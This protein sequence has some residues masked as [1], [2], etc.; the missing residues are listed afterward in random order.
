MS[1]KSQQG[2]TQDSS[3]ESSLLRHID[4]LVSIVDKNYQ[5]RAISH[6][7]EL[8]FGCTQEEIIGK[9]VHEVHGEDVFQNSLKPQLDKTLAGEEMR[10]Q[11]SRPNHLGKT[12][13]LDVRH[14]VYSGPLTEGNGVAIVVRDI[15]D[16]I[17]ANNALKEERKLL[18][19]V[20]D[21]IPDF[22]FTKNP[23]GTYQ[24]CNKSFTEFLG[25]KRNE[26]IGKTDFEL[27]SHAS[28]EYISN[29]DSEVR[30]SQQS[31]RHDEWVTYKDG[32][33][34]LLDMHKLPLFDGDKTNPGI[35]GIGRNVTY[36][37]EAEQK[38]LMAALVFDATP[39]P[40]IIL[41]EKGVVISSNEAA[42]EQFPSLQN[43]ANKLH[44][45]DIFYCPATKAINLE[46]LADQN[47][48]WC[49]E[50]YSHDSM[51]HLATINV[52]HGQARQADKYVLIIRDENTHKS[53]TDN[54]KDKAYQDALTGLPNRRLF[55][56]RLESA[57]LRAERQF[58]QLAVLYIDLN[59]FKP[60]NDQHGHSAGDKA[61]VQIAQR[62]K[63]NFRTTDTLARL[64]G[65]EFVALV[66][67]DDKHQA[68]AIAR[69]VLNNLTAPLDLGVN[70]T[71]T[72]SAS[73]GI[74]LFPSS[75]GNAEELIQKAD[76]AMY[77]AK[78]DS[79]LYYWIYEAEASE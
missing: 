17:E 32:R 5:Y 27:M 55:Y 24:A 2:P 79:N 72:I 44:I 43:K 77:K 45:S 47:G 33:K 10:F 11:F 9:Y 46:T 68:E 34:R 3:T 23:N 60:I 40:C 58:N 7:Y 56:S 69:K 36:E 76:E 18:N 4:D 38:L 67:I 73:I 78:R 20:I 31:Q 63:K 21:S 8:F 61:L 49:G 30:E 26:I 22:I 53:F 14:T 65:D 54:L 75:A 66:N 57:L 39:D 35:L 1:S 71:P 59:N 48:S 41:S 62:L 52:V 6:G 25:L 42:Q 12:R 64:G 50:I 15:T 74:S 70:I 37:R 51:C 16:N 13:H 29:K 19:T 28:A